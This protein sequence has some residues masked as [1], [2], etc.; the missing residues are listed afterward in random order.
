MVDYLAQ[1]RTRGSHRRASALVLVALVGALTMAMA[2]L[3]PATSLAAEPPVV[4]SVSP[5]DGPLAGGTPVD[6]RGAHFTGATEVKFGSTDATSFTVNSGSR[7]TATSPAGTGV[8]DV[9]VTTPSGTS[10]TGPADHF[11]YGPNVTGVSPSRG[12]ASGGT[13]VTVTGSDLSAATSVKFGATDATSFKV[14]SSSSITAVSPEGTG[15]VDVTITDP[16]ATSPVSSVDQFSYVLPPTVTSVSPAVGTEAGGTEVTVTGTNLNEVTA[17]DF[18]LS[19][20]S[21]FFVNNEGSLTAVSPPGTG[22]VDVT[23]TAFGGTSLTSFADQFRYEPPPTVTGVSPETGRAAG[24]TSVTITGTN[25]AEDTA[26]DFGSSSATS[27][28]VNSPSSITAVSPKGRPG[29]TV[30]VTVTTLGGISPTSAA[31]HFRYLQNAPLLV[32]EISPNHGASSGGTPVTITGS[33]F[34]GATAVDFGSAS[35]TSFRVTAASRIKAVA[36]PGT[37]TIDVTVTTPEGTSPTSS[38][39]EFS[40][41]SSPPTVESVSP[42][43][44]R[45]KGGTKVSIKGTNLAGATEVHFGS[46]PATRFQVNQEG[47]GIIAVNPAAAVVGE[48]TVDVTVTTPEGTSPISAADRFSY[49]IAPPVISSVSPREGKAAGGTGVIISG[50]NFIEVMAV[51]FGL[52]NATEFTVN[53]AGSITAVAPAMTVGKVNVS[54]TT[55][56]GTSGHGL[57]EVFGEEGPELVPC[58]TSAEHFNVVEP[59]I[60]SVTPDTGSAAGGTIVTVTGTGFG[61]GTSATTFKFGSTPATSVNCTSIATC[62]VVA[63]ARS[64]GTVD[65][66][67]TIPGAEVTQR[68]TQRNRPAD[69]FTYE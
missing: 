8:V 37:G 29:E 3:V 64:A 48:R 9:T 50:E 4:S 16:E 65:V 43:E 41:V 54:V 27:V 24:G 19:P 46:A 42:P 55:P 36:P 13:S 7:I 66:K 52:V 56:Y 33:A 15:T 14:N 44:G 45:E 20:A 23:V 2:A 18:G 62:T 69:Q 25:L 32:K 5:N 11:A 26:V 35:A 1:R 38:A 68:N 39:D 10:A 21:F 30:D 60:T 17:V 67:A 28:V 22:T 53:S 12:P 57:C 49:K 63:P 51:K 31:D 59:T 47:T 61:V 40:Y 58:P 34:V 6:I